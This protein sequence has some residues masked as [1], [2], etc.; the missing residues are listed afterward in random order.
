[1][2]PSG[3]TEISAA[4]IHKGAVKNLLD[5]IFCQIKI[6]TMGRSEA[7]KGPNE[8]EVLFFTKNSY[9]S[10]KKL[11]LF[12]GYLNVFSHHFAQ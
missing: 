8:F 2:L 4:K 12:P 7:E 1:V 11:S 5:R 3:L 9:I 6:C 10:L